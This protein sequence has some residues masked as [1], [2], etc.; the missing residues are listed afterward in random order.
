MSPELSVDCAGCTLCLYA[1][2]TSLAPVCQ[3]ETVCIRRM[4]DGHR[5]GCQILSVLLSE[6]GALQAK[7][8]SASS[9]H[10]SVVNALTSACRRS[11]FRVEASSCERSRDSAWLRSLQWRQQ[12]ISHLIHQTQ[13]MNTVGAACAAPYPLCRGVHV[14][15]TAAQPTSQAGTEGRP[16]ARLWPPGRMPQPPTAALRHRQLPAHSRCKHPPAAAW[17][18]PACMQSPPG[19]SVRPHARIWDPMCARVAT[20]ESSGRTRVFIPAL[21]LLLLHVHNMVLAIPDVHLDG[22]QLGGKAGMVCRHLAQP[23]CQK[24]LHGSIRP[25]T[26]DPWHNL[27]AGLS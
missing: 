3:V 19:P 26:A 8:T 24:L 6:E 13:D 12:M 17:P 15:A 21:Q 10:F 27:H 5:F 23:E 9:S 16:A 20:A 25:A 18:R 7:V 11:L 22:A 14:H 4:H 2:Q 1:K